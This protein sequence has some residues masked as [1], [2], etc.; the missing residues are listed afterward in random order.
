MKNNRKGNWT[1]RYMLINMTYFAVFCLI[2]AY[3]SV[4][5]LDKG[6]TNTQIGFCL[7]TANIISV[8]VQPLV[9]GMIDKP[10][11]LTNRNVSIFATA[12]MIVG[13][14]L[15]LVLEN[16]FI[17]VFVIYALI[18]MVQ[19][20]YQPLIIAMNFEYAKAGCNINFGFARGMGSCGFA[21]CSAIIGGV[22]AKNGVNTLMFGTIIVLSIALILLFTFIKPD[23]S[24]ASDAST[25]L[26]NDEISGSG[27]AHNGL[28]E[29]VRYYPRFSVFLVGVVC[30]FFAHNAI[31]DYLIQVITPLGGNETQMGYAIFIA[32]LLELPTMSIVTKIID[33]V[34]CSTLLKFA[35]VMFLIKTL[36]LTLATNMIG[37]YISE[38]FQMGAYAVLIPV[39]AYFVNQAM[40]ELDQVKGQAFVNCGITLGGVFSSIICGRIL[41]I[42][43]PHMMLVISCIVTAVGIVLTFYGVYEKSNE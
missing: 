35:G 26:L 40:E 19:M 39:S 11:V 38:A 29:F 33:K 9:A 28:I 37:V 16:S 21:I 22:V 6:F 4:Y 42:Y 1:L 36:I 2:H 24:D 30:F 15:L 41:D 5:L 14:G 18:Y 8:I 12:L 23:G 13:A 3:S 32:A 27:Q 20:A 43:G 25:G 34:K 17:A 7:A 31:N 10:G